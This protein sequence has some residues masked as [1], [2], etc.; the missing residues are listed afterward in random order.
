MNGD[1]R[2][3]VALTA[4]MN[5]AVRTLV[6]ARKRF[7]AIAEV[8]VSINVVPENTYLSGVAER[9]YR[10]YLVRGLRNE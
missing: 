10:E 8:L 7:E 1:E 6:Y 2:T 9:H 4:K 3:E 5:E